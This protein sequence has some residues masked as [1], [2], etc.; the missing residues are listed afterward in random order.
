MAASIFADVQGNERV[1]LTDTLPMYEPPVYSETT[2]KVCRDLARAV[3]EEDPVDRED[4]ILQLLKIAVAVGISPSLRN[5]FLRAEA[6]FLVERER[7]QQIN[8][9]DLEH[10][11]H[12]R[13]QRERNLARR[14]EA[15]NQRERALEERE[16]QLEDHSIP[17]G[18]SRQAFDIWLDRVSM[19]S[20]LSGRLSSGRSPEPM[21]HTNMSEPQEQSFP[22]GFPRQS[23][24]IWLDRISIPSRMSNRLSADKSPGPMQLDSVMET[25][26]AADT[27]LDSVSEVE[28]DT[29]PELLRE[30]NLRRE[31]PRPPI[32]F[33]ILPTPK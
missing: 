16:R 5:Q 31:S 6:R 2:F 9:V 4:I 29:K 8:K 15:L 33:F 13:F 20:R 18:F 3:D 22:Q 14:E 28:G 19:A 23:F 11:E 10:P 1:R 21:Q 32:P 30:V 27:R 7:R 24:D 25:R 17:Q 12:T 26:T